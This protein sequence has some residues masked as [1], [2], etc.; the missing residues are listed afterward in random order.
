[1]I[2]LGVDTSTRAGSVAVLEQERILG[3]LN[4]ASGGHHQGRLL[5]SID[6]LLDLAELDITK[7]SVLAVALGP[8]TFTGLRVG[9][10]TVKG[11]ALAGGIP[12][13]G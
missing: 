13:V 12:A 11:I 5:R 1:M 2:G 9:I 3:E 4:L 10:A 7:I 8:G 6:F